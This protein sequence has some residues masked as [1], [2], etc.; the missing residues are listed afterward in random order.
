MKLD[1]QKRLISR[2]LGVGK[3]R[4]WLDPARAKDIKEAITRADL[5]ALIEEGAIKIKKKRGISRFR[6]KKIQEQKRKGRRRGPGSRKG[7]KSARV[8][9][10][11]VWVNK[12]RVQRSFLKELKNTGKITKTQYRKLYLLS[13]GGFFRSISHIKLY[14]DKEFGVKV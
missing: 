1:Q 11:Q 8:P 2:I 14:I 3:K 7:K 6:A 13:K 9:H 5:L 12:I 4:I 10:A